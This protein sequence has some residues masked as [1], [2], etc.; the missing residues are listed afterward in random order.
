[1]L[2]VAFVNFL[3]QQRCVFDDDDDDDDDDMLLWHRPAV[4]AAGC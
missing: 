2:E 1:L 3:Y 4:T